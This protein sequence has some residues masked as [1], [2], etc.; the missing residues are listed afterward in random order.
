MAGFVELTYLHVIVKCESLLGG[1][2]KGRCTVSLLLPKVLF[3]RCAFSFPGLFSAV[4]WAP[5]S[6]GG[7]SPGSQ[8]EAKRSSTIAKRS[9]DFN[10]FSVKR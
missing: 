7:E 10:V 9:H 1:H 8:V 6:P 2:G 4:S 3:V 5:N